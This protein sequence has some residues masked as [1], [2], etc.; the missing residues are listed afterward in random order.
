MKKNL[1]SLNDL[2]NEGY[3]FA[4]IKI[5]ETEHWREDIQKQADKIFGVYLVDLTEPTHCCELSVSYPADNIKNF[6]ENPRNISE[7]ELTE[8]ELMANGI[9]EISYLSGYSHYQVEKLYRA[10]DGDKEEVMEYESGTPTVC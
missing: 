2:S 8:N 1:K 10:E 9:G 5:D 7:D 6:F 3:T 4:V